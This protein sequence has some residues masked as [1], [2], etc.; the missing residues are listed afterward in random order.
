MKI[1]LIYPFFILTGLVIIGVLIYLRFLSKRAMKTI[2]EMIELNGKSGYDIHQFL[3]NSLNL[4]RKLNING[5]Y[6]NIS[7]LNTKLARSS[8]PS[9]L[10]V[11]KTIRREDYQITIGIVPSHSKGEHVFI[12]TVVLEILSV[13]IEMNILIHIKVIHEAFYKFSKLQTFLL[14]DVK[15]LAQFIGSLSY[16][17]HHL[18][19]P[20]K[21]DRFIDNLKETLP[22]I[23]RS[24]AKIIGLLGMQSET[25]DRRSPANTIDI[26]S[27]LENLTKHYKLSCRINGQASV[28][29]EEYMVISI[30]D[31]L[32]KNIYDKSLQ[33]PNITCRLDIE[34]LENQLKIIISDTGDFT[35]DRNRLFEP[36]YSTKTSGLGIGLYQ[37]QNI[38]HAM[39]GD[40][41]ILPDTP[42]VT[43]E[44][45][46]PKTRKV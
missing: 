31:N 27:L 20:D 15:N 21:K 40:I 5:Y 43:F 29:A 22:V 28:I 30:F 9:V 36:F 6:Y 45:I 10:Q 12:N 32:L 23:S 2:I 7:Y 19:T 38:A 37:S 3:P 16:N 25:D 44:V 13:L 26:K 14:H 1:E 11:E 18:E 35:G 8:P 46:L 42:G 24:G 41:R 34:D 39:G 17:V 4:L 33:E